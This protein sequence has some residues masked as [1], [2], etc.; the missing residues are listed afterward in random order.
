VQATTIAI[1]SLGEVRGNGTLVGNVQNGGLVAPG[2]SLG[3]LDITGQYTQSV[4]GELLVELAST[5]SYDRLEITGVTTLDGTLD[6][7]L[8]GG[9][10][11]SSGDT[12]DIITAAGGISGRFASKLLPALN[13]GLFLDVEY[14]ATTVSLVAAGVLGDYNVNGVVDAA[15]YVVW[16]ETLGQSASVLAADGNGNG[17]I[18]AGDYDEWK[19]HFG[20]SAGSGAGSIA[21]SAAVPEPKAIMLLLLGIVASAA[22]RSAQ[23]SRDNKA[24]PRGVREALISRITRRFFL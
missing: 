2:T 1:N 3:T 6:V 23:G 22:S 5:A 11:P 21:D 15:D 20:Q 12:F 18:D 10:T 16:R 24:G 17:T 14:A 19:A 4:D 7:T 13:G 9:F 8:L